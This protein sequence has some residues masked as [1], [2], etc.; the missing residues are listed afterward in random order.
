[1]RPN[2]TSFSN[3]LLQP[4]IVPKILPKYKPKPKL[5]YNYTDLLINL[6]FIAIFL[7]I[8]GM[9]LNYRY[10]NKSTNAEKKQNLVNFVNTIKYHID[11]KPNQK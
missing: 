3:K 5:K 7:L 1:M 4:K 6:L 8:I 2:L 10:K 11:N 9:I